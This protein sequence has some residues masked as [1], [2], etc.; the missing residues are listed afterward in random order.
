MASK[1]KIDITDPA[2][3]KAIAEFN[4][5]NPNDFPVINPN[6]PNS[7][8]NRNLPISNVGGPPDLPAYKDNGLPP[9]M[10][11]DEILKALRNSPND[12]PE[13][14]NALL[15]AA[16][17]VGVGAAG[18]NMNLLGAGLNQLG[19][20]VGTG[21][22]SVGSA[23]ANNVYPTAVLADMARKGFDP[24]SELRQGMNAE[25]I[26]ASAGVI[27]NEL[28]KSATGESLTKQKGVTDLL[29]SVGEFLGGGLKG[30]AQGVGSAVGNVEQG[31]EPI[32]RGLVDVPSAFMKGY[33]ATQPPKPTPTITAPNDAI[34]SLGGQNIDQHTLEQIAN[35]MKAAGVGQNKPT[36]PN[37]LQRLHQGTNQALAQSE[38]GPSADITSYILTG[39]GIYGNQ[40]PFGNNPM[41]QTQAPSAG[42][43]G[44]GN[45]VYDWKESGIPAMTHPETK[46]DATTASIYTP[47]VT[48]TQTAIDQMVHRR[49]GLM[50]SGNPRAMQQASALDEQITKA[51]AQVKQQLDNNKEQVK[52]STRFGNAESDSAIATSARDMGASTSAL[53]DMIYKAE[54]Y[55][56]EGDINALR[57]LAQLSVDQVRKIEGVRPTGA[58]GEAFD[59][60]FGHVQAL[61][62]NGNAVQA[63]LPQNLDGTIKAM[64]ELRKVTKNEGNRLANI[65]GVPADDRIRDVYTN[66]FPQTDH[67]VPVVMDANGQPKTKDGKLVAPVVNGFNPDGTLRWGDPTVKPDVNGYYP[68]VK[69]GVVTL[70]FKPEE[71][72]DS[73]EK[74]VNSGQLFDP[75]TRASYIQNMKII[76]TKM[77]QAQ[78]ANLASQGKGF[79]AGVKEAVNEIGNTNP[80]TGL[81]VDTVTPQ[82]VAKTAPVA[83]TTPKKSAPKAR[84]EL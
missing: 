43:N 57:A 16:G 11:A 25:N 24:N 55:G 64:L 19:N 66:N 69:P 38:F 35:Y 36:G 72:I 29:R 68:D 53:D 62:G 65:A 31:V 4:L 20:N 6:D 74:R 44:A 18:K 8:V 51:Q 22:R 5:S 14:R 52:A 42:A 75:R 82:S 77:A 28:G 40:I 21:I 1:K 27:G 76:N 71:Y 26:P 37:F 2:I 49:N 39:K 41:N 34:L 45:Q 54:K 73:V 17:M 23:V 3:Q 48:Q 32:G 78:A 60:A 63:F 70:E 50:M 67:S 7:P 79:V 9:D 47:D 80:N 61:L 13:I 12:S 46:I 59:S 84:K 56:K 30:A 83:P 33:S 58:Q 15:G 81:P 10:P